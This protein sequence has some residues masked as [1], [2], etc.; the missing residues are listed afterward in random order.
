[1]NKFNLKHAKLDNLL[2]LAK[3]IG[4]KHSLSEMSLKQLASLV[5]WRI[6]PRRE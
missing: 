4:L 1:M 2:R 3:Y 6:K 5:W